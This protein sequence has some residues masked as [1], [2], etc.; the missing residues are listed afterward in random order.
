MT[1]R[2]LIVVFVVV[3]EAA[4]AAASPPCFIHVDHRSSPPRP[5]PYVPLLPPLEID[6]RRKREGGGG[7]K[8]GEMKTTMKTTMARL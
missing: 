4:A 6:L 8:G 5:V 7:R 3:A 2:G 1:L